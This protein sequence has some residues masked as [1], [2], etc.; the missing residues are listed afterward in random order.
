MPCQGQ[1]KVTNTLFWQPAPPIGH[2]GPFSLFFKFDKGTF[3]GRIGPTLRHLLFNEL[4]TCADPCPQFT[5]ENTQKFSE[6]LIVGKIA[7]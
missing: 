3:S 7:L 1:P 5:A 6:N 2:H 4:K